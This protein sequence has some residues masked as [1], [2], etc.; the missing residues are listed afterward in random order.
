MRTL[1]GLLLLALAIALLVSE[2]VALVDPAL[3]LEIPASAAIY[4]QSS[5]WYVHAVWFA[6]AAALGWTSMRLLNRGILG[7]LVRGRGFTPAER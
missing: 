6:V 1:S 4:I 5:P 7:R 3:G 2:L